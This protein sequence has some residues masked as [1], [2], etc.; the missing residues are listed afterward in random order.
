MLPLFSRIGRGLGQTARLGLDCLLPPRCPSCGMLVQE[1]QTLHPGLCPDCFAALSFIAEPLC[2]CCGL[3]FESLAEAGPSGR[4]RQCA[5]RPPAFAQARAAVTYDA[6]ARRLLLPFKHADRPDLSGL[7]AT[8]MLRCGR[9]L[10]TEADLLLPVPLHRR[11]LVQRRYNQAALLA[12]RLARAAGRP[13]AATALRRLR[14]TPP[15]GALSAG[16]RRA[17]VAGA[18]TVSPHA[19]PLI[20]GRRILLIDDVLTSGATASAC[21]SALRAAGVAAVDVLVVARVPDP[22][23][24]RG[25]DGGRPLVPTEDADDFIGI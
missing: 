8:L 10:L 19:A 14:P 2:A 17:V 25:P 21:A 12:A 18:F 20:A 24:A 22:R 4:C 5:I 11:R 6:A 9:P 7:L 1:S 16:A 15:L 13:W 23:R 3:P